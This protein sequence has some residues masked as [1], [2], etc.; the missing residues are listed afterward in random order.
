MIAE[1]EEIKGIF[2]RDWD[3]IGVAGMPEAA[4]EYDA[5]AFEVFTSLHKGAT[6][7]SISEYLDTIET[8]HMGLSASSGRSG[9]I[10]S[11]VIALHERYET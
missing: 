8:K 2:L 7:T 10:A 1:L 9:E 5:Y 4:D 3:P 6:A 11:K